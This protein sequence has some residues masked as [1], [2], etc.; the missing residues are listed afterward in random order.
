MYRK[1]CYFYTGYENIN[2]LLAQPAQQLNKGCGDL[3][4]IFDARHI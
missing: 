2:D 4:S 1:D 3:K